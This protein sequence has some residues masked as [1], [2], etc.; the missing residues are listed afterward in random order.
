[1][2]DQQVL[3]VSIVALCEINRVPWPDVKPKVKSGACAV[4]IEVN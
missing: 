1:M 4:D 3:N 2:I